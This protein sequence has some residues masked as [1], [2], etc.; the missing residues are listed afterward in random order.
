MRLPGSSNRRP[1]PRRNSAK[2][3]SNYRRIRCERPI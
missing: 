2:Y 1:P 3:F